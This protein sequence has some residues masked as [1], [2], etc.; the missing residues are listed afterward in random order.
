[1]CAKDG[2]C[3]SD[4]L[5]VGCG[6]PQGSVLGPILFNLYINDL[7]LAVR[8]EV[9]Q[10]AEDTA[11]FNHSKVIKEI[12]HVIDEDMNNLYIWLNSNKLKLNIKKTNYICFGVKKLPNIDIMLHV[13]NNCT[14]CSENGC[15]TINRTATVKYLGLWFDE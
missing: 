2:N 5:S 10:F 14:N 1:M 8:G 9:Y 13:V 15:P 3:I 6:V 4:Q 12:E 7:H 11:I